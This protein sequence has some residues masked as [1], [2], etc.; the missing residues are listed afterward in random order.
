VTLFD[1]DNLPTL[2]PLVPSLLGLDWEAA[3]A[4]E[5]FL[6]V[7][8]SEPTLVARLIGLAN[9]VAYG[10]PGTQFH[11]AEAALR[12]IGLRRS[13]QLAIAILFSQ[14]ITRRLPASSSRD[15]WLHALCMAHAAEE[16]A[17]RSR[18]PS[19][20][21]A[22]FLGLV[23]DLGYMAMEYTRPGTLAEAA[24]L[25]GAEAMPPTAAETRLLGLDHAELTARLLHR[26]QVPAETV[27][28]I[29]AH[30][31][32]AAAGDRMAAL[33]LGAEA[34]ANSAALV[35]A[36]FAESGLPVPA[37]TLA[38]TEL[39]D[40]LA[41]GLGLAADDVQAIVDRLIR[42][43]ESFKSSATLLRPQGGRDD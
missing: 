41:A 35:A 42:E 13:I 12:R 5:R 31:T 22:Y 43:V 19:P 30:H 9:S 38:G 11:T 40:F 4:N 8:E 39:D 37:S 33:L 18:R 6:R 20:H 27:G 32:D 25:V 10:V 23:H 29:L 3:D 16:I 1:L 36:L 24:R 26:W 14:P 21:D 7:A 28:P 34:I 17:R 2:S 15:L